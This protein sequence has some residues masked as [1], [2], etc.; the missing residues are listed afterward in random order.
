[1]PNGITPEEIVNGTD[2]EAYLPKRAEFAVAITFD[3]QLTADDKARVQQRVKDVL[4]AALRDGQLIPPYSR[5]PRPR[6][7][8]VQPLHYRCEHCQEVVSPFVLM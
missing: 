2:E 3:D 1:M 6:L 5:L 8:G 7:V 4:E